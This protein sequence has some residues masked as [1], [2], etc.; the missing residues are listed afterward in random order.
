LNLLV[1]FQKRRR[2]ALTS[3]DTLLVDADN[4]DGCVVVVVV[5]IVDV[6]DVVRVVDVV[7]VVRV[8]DVVDVVGV[9]RVVDVVVVDV[10]R[11][12]DLVRVVDVVV[13]VVDVVVRV[14]DVVRVDDVRV[15][16]VV[17]AVLLCIVYSFAL[18]LPQSV[19]ARIPTKCNPRLFRELCKLDISCVMKDQHS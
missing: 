10:V 3:K 5:R 17:P 9:V 18:V 6:V 11:V 8:V 13:R 1:C 2:L 15:V 7:D 12:V 14:V 4:V 19:L 16:D